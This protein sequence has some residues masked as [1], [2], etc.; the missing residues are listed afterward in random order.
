MTV[1]L[2]NQPDYTAQSGSTYKANIDGAFDSGERIF[3]DFAPHAQA[4]PVMT[5]RLDAGHVFDGMTLL[6]VAAQS[7]ATI[8]A[9]T[10]NPRIDRIVV[11]RLTGVVSVITGT[12]AASPSAPAI[13]A[14]KVPVAQARIETTSTTITNAMITDERDLAWLGVGDGIIKAETGTTY[15]VVLGDKGKLV[16]HSNAAAIAVTLPVATTAGFIGGFY[17]RCLNIGAGTVTITPT[18]STINGGAT[19]VL[20]Q[21]QSALIFSDGTNYQA[22]TSTDSLTGV[23][24]VAAGGTGLASGTSGGILGYTA[25]GIL[26]SSIL[27][28][29][30]ALM[31]GGGAGATPTPM[32][33]LGTTT[34]VLH[35]NA[36]GAPTFAAVSLT[37]DVSGILP[38][39][40]G[41]TSG[42]TAAAGFDALSPVT[43][44]GDL[45]Y[46]NAT[47]NARLAVG[48]ANT[49][50]RS[51]GTDPGWSS[52]LSGLTLTAPTI[53]GGAATALTGLGIR[54]TGT[55][56]FDL[57]LANTENLAAGRTLTITVNDAARTVDLGGN[58]TLANAFVTSGAFSMTLTA[59]AATNVTLPTTGTLATLGGTETLTNKS[60]TSPTITGT[61]VIAI[62]ATAITTFLSTGI[63][64]NASAL[65]MTIGSAGDIGINVVAQTAYKVSIYRAAT[66]NYTSADLSLGGSVIEIRQTDN[67]T[68]DLCSLFMT[69]FNAQ[70]IFGLTYTSAQVG[71]LVFGL[72][73]GSAAVAELMRLGPTGMLFLNDTFNGNMTSGITVNGGANDNQ[74]FCLK[75]SDVATGLTT[76]TTPDVETDDFYTIS[77]YAALT[78]GVVMQA[79]GENA[80]VTVNLEFQSIGGQADATKSTAGL[81]LMN[82]YVSQHDGV[83][84]LAD[85]AANG[86]GYSFR[87]RDGGADVTRFVL[88]KDGDSHQDVG[89]AWTNFDEHDDVGL[90]DALSVHVSRRDDPI[91]G[92]FRDF[93]EGNRSRLA[94]LRLVTFNDNGHHFVNMSRLA[95]LSV[96]AIRQ[97]GRKERAMVAEIATI[98]SQFQLI[99]DRTWH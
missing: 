63:D 15:T 92:E 80:A 25:T 44:R 36:S 22:M 46:R 60:L 87:F 88:D 57:T 54:S 89:T 72:T 47:V 40:N 67:D 51:D 13:T 32:A 21:Y 3:N 50:L 83:N 43:T 56:A 55:G 81:G 78:G 86:N 73:N 5:V 77:K 76:I 37:A 84:A 4:T 68:G 97:L 45:I 38:I 95:M 91:R 75:N 17:Y 14:G 52:T 53:N 1:S 19:L 58:L 90:L 24:G 7:S 2:Y 20:K 26:A 93:I 71:A 6:A 29:A 16:T 82:F 23:L 8:V 42:A 18:T 33:S 31:L 94:D 9:P 10:T 79:L 74:H 96:G 39:A 30:S 27:L 41:G 98:K 34:T 99:E 65:A 12:E 49:V 11:D 59:T 62:G 85:V 61:P 69:N 35:G 48:A 64:D 70:A 28:T 66:A